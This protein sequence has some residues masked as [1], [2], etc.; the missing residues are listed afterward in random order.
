MSRIPEE[1]CPRRGNGACRGSEVGTGLAYSS[2]KIGVFAQCAVKNR[3]G[4]ETGWEREEGP[5]RK[6]LV[7]HDKQIGFGS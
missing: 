7:G 5:G 2:G 3:R 6:G 1:S 4:E